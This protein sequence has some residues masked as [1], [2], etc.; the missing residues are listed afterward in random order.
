MGSHDRVQEGTLE[1]EKGRVILCAP[2]IQVK[3]N[4]F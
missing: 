4:N 3:P 2:K 1:E